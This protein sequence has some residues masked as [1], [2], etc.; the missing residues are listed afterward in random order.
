MKN[1]F[2]LALICAFAVFGSVTVITP[3]GG[4]I[5]NRGSQ[6]EISWNDSFPEAVKLELYDN[7]IFYSSIIDSTDSDGS[8]IWDVPNNIFGSN[9]KI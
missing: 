1:V 2:L 3:N 9:Y 6:Y 5:L 4:E 8:Y 7:D